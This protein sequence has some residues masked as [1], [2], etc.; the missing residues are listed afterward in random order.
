MSAVAQIDPGPIHGDTYS[1]KAVVI[2]NRKSVPLFSHG[3]FSLRQT[4]DTDQPIK[5]LSQYRH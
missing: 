1:R 3:G 5:T 4:S 2:Y